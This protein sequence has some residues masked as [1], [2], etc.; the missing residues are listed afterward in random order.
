MGYTVLGGLTPSPASIAQVCTII[1]I[2]KGTVAVIAARRG[3]RMIQPAM[4][5][6][7]KPA[8]GVMA[9]SRMLCQGRSAPV[10][11]MLGTLGT[12]GRMVVLRASDL[13]WLLVMLEDY[14]A[15]KDGGKGVGRPDGKARRGA[16][17]MARA[18]LR[19]RWVRVR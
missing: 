10:F 3:S 6:A 17:L 5:A 8:N 1:T 9:T 19:V 16:G 14:S 11:S 15:W 12:R 13:R 7:T 2:R 18:A 4:M